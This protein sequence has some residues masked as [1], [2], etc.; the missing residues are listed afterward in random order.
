MLS[1]K[2]LAGYLSVVI[3]LL[4]YLHYFIS[5][6]KGQTKPHALS[7][8][9]WG[10]LVSVAFYA[11]YTNKAGPGA[12]ATG[13]VAVACFVIAAIAVFR[14]EKNITKS[15]WITFIGAFLIV[16]IWYITKNPLPAVILAML[17][18]IFGYYPT[19]RKSYYK[20]YE[21]TL[22]AYVAGILQAAFALLA[23]KEYMLINILYPVF[24]TLINTS[25]VMLVVY[26]RNAG[27]TVQK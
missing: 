18:D 14:G 7:W 26:R 27:I 17:I 21:E 22:V 19:F 1:E 16:P 9:I 5:I 8:V 15:D 25:F 4:G 20:P 13:F 24:V 10:F 11:Q 2:E 3:A 6:F 23:M 12:W